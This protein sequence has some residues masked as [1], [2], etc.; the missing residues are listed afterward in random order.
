MY[1][2]MS[3]FVSLLTVTPAVQRVHWLR[4]RAQKNRWDEELL[5]L[6]YEMEWTTRALLH[7]ARVW[8]E[9][10]EEPN[11]DPGLKAYAARQH[12]NGDPWHR[13]RIVCSDRQIRSISRLYDVI[14]GHE[15]CDWIRSD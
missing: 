4:A 3:I 10:F 5:L 15:I 2:M 6:K 13:T 1:A 8:Q 14:S 9:R 12:L 11:A 7:K